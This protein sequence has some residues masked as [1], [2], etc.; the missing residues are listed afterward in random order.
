MNMSGLSL[1]QVS[2]PVLIKRR[3]SGRVTVNSIGMSKRV[4]VQK[5]GTLE[6]VASTHSK[7][8]GTW[9]IRGTPVM[10]ERSLMAIALDDTGQY[11][12]EILDYLSQVE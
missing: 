1:S 10:P 9:E 4:L 6:Y 11:N 7:A 2:T 8:D 12:A 5:R 3:L